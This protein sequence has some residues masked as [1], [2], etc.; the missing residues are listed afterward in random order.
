MIEVTSVMGIAQHQVRWEEFNAP[1]TPEEKV[2]LW[3]LNAK[4]AVQLAGAISYDEK[5]TV[6]ESRV[7]K[8]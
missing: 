8:E 5:K 3:W 1:L 6:I 7:F 4:M 2:R